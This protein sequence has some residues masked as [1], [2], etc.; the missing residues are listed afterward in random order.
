MVFLAILFL[1]IEAVQ[2]WTTFVND[3]GTFFE[4]NIGA[5][6]SDAEF[7]LRLIALLPQ[8]PSSNQ[9][10]TGVNILSRDPLGPSFQQK[11]EFLKSVHKQKS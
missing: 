4:F 6:V 11:K 9:A 7:K 8:L 5:I 3:I 10:F 1:Q 2:G